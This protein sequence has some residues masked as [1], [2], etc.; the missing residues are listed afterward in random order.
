ILV[1]DSEKLAQEVLEELRIQVANTKHAE[2][3]SKALA[4]IQSAIILVK[5]LT[6]GLEVINEYA[7]EHLE[8]Q[9]RDAA[10]VAKQI[11]NAGAVFVGPF[12]PVSLGDYLAGS[13]HVLPTGGC[14]C[15]SSGL[16]VQ[17]FLR[18]V[19]FINYDKAALAE[20]KDALKILAETEDLP[21][22]S[23]AVEVRFENN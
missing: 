12:A 17:T 7:A 6:Q 20:V 19:Q 14:A 11:K 5:D 23:Q 1:T 3:I 2:R 10:V 22:H 18:G 21:A 13:N 8:I 15:H 9:T 16:S 4:G